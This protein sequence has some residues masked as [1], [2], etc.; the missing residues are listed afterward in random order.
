MHPLREVETK[1]FIEMAEEF[2]RQYKPPS[3]HKLATNLLPNFFKEVMNEIKSDIS[4]VPHCSITT[5]M[6]QSFQTDDYNTIT[7]HYIDRTEKCLKSK[8]LTCSKFNRAHTA[9]NLCKDMEKIVNEYKLPLVGAVADKAANIRAAKEELKTKETWTSTFLDFI[10]ID[11][12]AH[13]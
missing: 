4:K 8:I 12:F 5:D 6:W 10:S 13:G 2:D 7:A 11:C 1:E 9:E 3:R